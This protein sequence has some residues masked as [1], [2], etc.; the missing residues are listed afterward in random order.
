MQFFD[1][2]SVMVVFEKT[3]NQLEMCGRKPR[4]TLFRLKFLRS[5]MLKERRTAYIRN[6]HVG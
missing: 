4:S 2:R 5:V 3:E 6:L 1:K